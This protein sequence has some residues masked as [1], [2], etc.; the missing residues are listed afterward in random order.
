[1]S[2]FVF[3]RSL[4]QRFCGYI[5]S[6]A[7]LAEDLAPP[8]PVPDPLAEPAWVETPENM[9]ALVGM[10]Q[11]RY[12]KLV[13]ARDDERREKELREHLFYSQV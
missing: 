5:Q 11:E 7:T 13:G 12:T 10:L 4:Y 1:M 2:D 6:P 3:F 9:R 8:V